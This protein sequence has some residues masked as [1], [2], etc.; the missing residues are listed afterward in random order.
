MIRITVYGALSS[1]VRGHALSAEADSV[2][3]LLE[4]LIQRFGDDFARMVKAAKI[5][6]NGQNVAF[7][8]GVKTRLNAGDEVVFLSPVAGG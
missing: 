2:K 4:V 1:V 6:H 3:E 7:N 5:F 8:R